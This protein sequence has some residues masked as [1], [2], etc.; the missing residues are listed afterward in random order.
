MKRYSILLIIL[1]LV[2]C[3]SC[4]KD[5]HA[6]VITLLGSNPAITGK[7]YPYHDAGAIALDE[8]DGDISDKIIVNSNVDTGAIGTYTVQYNVTDSDG[9]EA[10][11]VTRQVIVM[12][13][14]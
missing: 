7:G 10:D 1:I 3:Y 13:F 4:K 14:K 11:E 5:R 9:D 6:P 2:S 12:Y 8:E